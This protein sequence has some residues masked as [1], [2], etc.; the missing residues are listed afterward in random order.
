[1]SGR[2]APSSRASA[3]A[4]YKTQFARS[5][6]RVHLNNAGLAPIPA[7]A[8]DVVS[9]W[10]ARFHEEGFLTDADY[11]NAVA[12]ARASLGELIG[13]EP[14]E[15]AFFQSTSAA[16]SQVAFGMHLDAGSEVLTWDQ[17][18]GSLLY[19]WREACERAGAG[20]V[21]APSGPRLETPVEALLARL[22]HR[23]RV[24]ALSWVQFQS[25]AITDL[26]PIVEAAHGYGAWVV[27]DVMQGLGLMPFDM[28][29]LGVDAVCG[30][31]HKWL[32]SPVGVGFLA[33]RR[34]HTKQLRPLLIGSMT[35]G[36]CDDPVSSACVAKVDAARFESGSKQVLEIAA[37]GSSVEL[38]LA[39]GVDVIAAEAERVAT[40][41]RVGLIEQGHAVHAPHG[42]RQRGAI[43]NVSGPSVDAL[44]RRN[45]TFAV[46]GPGVRLS[47]HAFTTDDEIARVLNVT[48]PREAG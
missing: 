11:M 1:M 15:I 6:D 45:I 7:C 38:I 34:E 8:R 27:V 43:V 9:S 4:A 14:D 46:R 41:L 44:R 33:I 42:E 32:T 17:D 40:M 19:P 23:T 24:V 48:D 5:P 26:A 37:L 31:S 21:V 13:C 25:G 36:T 35:Y 3:L 2:G 18:Y 12:R 20:L 10:A 47:P 22:S 28:A 16:V 39:T 29:A 30:G